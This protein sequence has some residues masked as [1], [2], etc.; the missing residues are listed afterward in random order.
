MIAGVEVQTFNAAAEEAVV[1]SIK[2]SNSDWEDSIYNVNGLEYVKVLS[3]INVV[4]ARRRG[5][6]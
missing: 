3:S 4:R 2:H 1:D 6:P 5:Q